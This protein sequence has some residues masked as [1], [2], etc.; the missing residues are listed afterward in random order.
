MN[1]VW[2]ENPLATVIEL[3]EREK[4][5]LRDR[6]MIDELKTMLVGAKMDLEAG[7]PDEALKEL[8]DLESVAEEV[9]RQYPWMVEAFS[10]YH[11]GDCT[12]WPSACVK[13]HA[14]GHLGICTIEGLGKHAGNWIDGAFDRKN[15]QDKRTLDEA[16]EYLATHDPDRD[17]GADSWKHKHPETWASCQPRWRAEIK[18]AHEWLVQYRKEH[19]PND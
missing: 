19:F 8:G 14:E 1:I 10:S 11:V 15:G 2:N 17:A 6:I 13:C 18:A 12:C 5:T 7:K 3:D 16:I 9:D 4:A